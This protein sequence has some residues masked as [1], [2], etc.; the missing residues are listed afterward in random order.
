MDNAGDNDECVYCAKPL[1]TL[2]E[3]PAGQPESARHCPSC[4]HL[5]PVAAAKVDHGRARAP[6]LL[7]VFVLV[8]LPPPIPH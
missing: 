7:C 5:M 4:L 6:A 2:A 3:T 8:V 1:P